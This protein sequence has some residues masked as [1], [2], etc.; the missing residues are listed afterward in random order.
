MSD[1]HGRV[2]VA[3]IATYGDT[4][5]SFVQR[6]GYKGAFMPGYVPRTSRKAAVPVGLEFIDHVVGNQG[7]NEMD[8]IATWYEDVFGFHRIWTVDDKD[9]STAHTSLR[10]V[11][12]ANENEYVKM[13]INEPAE[14]LKKSQIQEYI[15]ANFGAG[16]QHI[17]MHTHD[18]VA[19]IAKLAAN[20]VEFLEVPD[21]Y[22]ASL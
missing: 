8:R 3:P 20:G 1:E 21:T 18:I 13:P 22:Y 16:V 10:S 15:D 6:D 17:A 9:V 5:H 2:I 14:G 4:H 7:D 11:V 19:T 12:V